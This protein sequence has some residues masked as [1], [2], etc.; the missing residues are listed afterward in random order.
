MQVF[1]SGATLIDGTGN[2]PNPDAVIAIE[3]GLI[4]GIGRRE[5]FGSALEQGQQIAVDGCTV[6]P[7]FVNCHEHVLAKRVTGPL[8]NI[9]LHPVEDLVAFGLH[10]ALITLREGVTTLR[11]MS[12]RA[13][14]SLTVKRALTQGYLLGPTMA[15]VPQGLTVT[16][17]YGSTFGK[18]ADTPAE[19]TKAARELIKAGADW[20]KCFASIEWEKDEGEPLSAMNMREDEM[21]AAFDVAHHHGKRTCAHAIL[22]EAIRAAVE[23]GAD[24]IEH[25]IMLSRATAELMATRG[26][27]LVPTLSGY[28]QHGVDW[29][30]G[31]GVVR[32]GLKLRPHHREALRHALDA[33]IP[34][35]FGTDTLGTFAEEARLMQ[36]YG[37]KPMAILESATRIGAKLLGMDDRIGTLESGKAADIVVLNGNPLEDPQAYSQVKMVVKAGKVMESASLPIR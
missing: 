37:M 19:F 2:P 36:E 12:S 11:D 9:M 13:G 34:I 22:D 3:N 29:G 32:H 26:T 7:G 35:A 31:A 8:R 21:R 27:Y 20:I 14:L 24:T 30:R 10:N 4:R 17:G 6:V 25:G 15:V 5:D 23:A 16:G 1:L 18:E 33:G 28:W